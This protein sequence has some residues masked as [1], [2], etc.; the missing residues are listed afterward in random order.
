LVGVDEDVRR[1]E[2]AVDDARTMRHRE[3]FCDGT[4]E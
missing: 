3:R 2:I 4:K 1:L